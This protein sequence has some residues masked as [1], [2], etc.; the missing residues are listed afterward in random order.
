[1]TFFYNIFTS[2]WDDHKAGAHEV[3]L[4]TLY[5]IPKVQK[6][7]I[8][9]LIHSCLGNAFPIMMMR[10]NSLTYI[11]VIES[12]VDVHIHALLE[13]LKEFRLGPNFDQLGIEW[14]FGIVGIL[15]PHYNST[16]N[17]N[18][19]VPCDF[20]NQ[21]I[22]YVRIEDVSIQELTMKG[23]F[24]LSETSKELNTLMIKNSHAI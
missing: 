2:L 6:N 13:L 21:L 10:I 3:N 20:G 11:K 14:F 9:D 5:C 7:Y 8:M 23:T 19:M 16:I 22:Y 18:F 12:L 4:P 24:K 17:P 15:P 1:M